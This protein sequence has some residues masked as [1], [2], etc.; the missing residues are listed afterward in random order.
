M[1]SGMGH[2]LR[3]VSLAIL[4]VGLA[5]CTPRPAYVAWPRRHSTHRVTHAQPPA[6]HEL[7]DAQKDALFR[8]FSDYEAQRDAGS[9]EAGK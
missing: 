1:G 5:G 2:D 3:L 8:K 7:T 4:A 9:T 6:Q